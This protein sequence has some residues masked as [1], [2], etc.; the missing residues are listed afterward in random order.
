MC[1]SLLTVNYFETH[2]YLFDN[3]RL[4]K[5]C[6]RHSPT[7]A[8]IQSDQALAGNTRHLHSC[9]VYV[10][11]VSEVYLHWFCQIGEQL[12]LIIVTKPH[13]SHS[14]QKFRTRKCRLYRNN[15]LKL[16]IIKQ[17]EDFYQPNRGVELVNKAAWDLS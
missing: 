14:C 8:Q 12:L 16:K 1:L 11:A 10:Q 9:I 5:F 17:N 2:S 15:A 13:P 4:M 6:D 3:N 7:Q